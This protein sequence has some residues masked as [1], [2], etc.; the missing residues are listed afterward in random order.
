M[1][2]HS[3][4]LTASAHPRPQLH[5]FAS[6]PVLAVRCVWPH[7]AGTPSSPVFLHH[8][9][10]LPPDVSLLSKPSQGDAISLTQPEIWLWWKQVWE[11][12]SGVFGPWPFMGVWDPFYET[13]S[14]FLAIFF[15]SSPS[16]VFLIF[17]ISCIWVFSV[18]VCLY[19][20]YKRGCHIPWKSMGHHMGAGILYQSSQHS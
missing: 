15:L 7:P 9:P 10:Y 19:N 12:I 3:S 5:N 8:Q 1:F 20:R 16:S 17:I 18:H 11:I 6:I 4:L 14:L 13:S 2:D